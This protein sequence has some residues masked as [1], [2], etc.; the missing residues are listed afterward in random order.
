MPKTRRQV[1]KG[2]QA[3][4]KRNRQM[5]ESIHYGT[6]D[7]L[8]KR[9]WEIPTEADEKNMIRRKEFHEKRRNKNNS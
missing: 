6:A 8:P 9:N 3:Q 1:E 4:E 2:S 7:T 5:N